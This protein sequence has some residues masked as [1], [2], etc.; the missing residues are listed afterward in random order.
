M[1]DDRYD[2]DYSVGRL[3]LTLRTRAQLSQ[4]ELGALIGVS[5]RSVQKWEGGD[6]YP[7]ESSLSRLLSVLLARG[8]FEAGREHEQA[9]ELWEMVAARGPRLPL[10]DAAWFLNLVPQREL[11]IGAAATEL[12]HS[13]ASPQ[14]GT[15]VAP[16]VDLAEAPDTA[17]LHGRAA[18][19]TMLEDWV[20]VDRCRI[21]ALLGMG[22][23]GKTSLAAVF[24]RSYASAFAR[25]VFR[26]LRN[27]PPLPSLLDGLLRTLSGQP[28]LPVPQR[29]DDKLS[30]L[31]GLLA[32][33]R[34]LL[35]LDNLET[36]M[37]DG[38]AAGNYRSGYADY[39]QL[40]QRL[41]EAPHQSCLLLTSR[42]KPRELG[43]LEGSA[44]PV[45][46]LALTGI[47]E[48]ACQAILANRDV[49]GQPGDWS[50]LTARYGGNPLALKLVAEPIR[51]LFGGDL[52]G[53]L[54]SE[55]A[56]FGGIRF[57][58]DEQF[59]RLSSLEQ[60][61]LYWMAVCR[62]PLGIEE[63]RLW[64]VLVIGTQERLEALE[65]LRR[66]FL[67]ERAG[68]ALR[69]TLQPVV[70][71][72]V[73]ERLIAAIVSE[74][75]GGNLQ[76]LRRY[77]LLQAQARAYVRQSQARVIVAPLLDMLRDQLKRADVV[78]AQLLRT[79]D[80]LRSVPAQEQSY[81]GGNLLNLLVQLGSDLRGRDLSGLVLWQA[82]LSGV[83]LP[84]VSLRD[85]DLRGT[86]F[87]E[88]F[89]TIVPVA[90]SP[91]GALLAAGSIDGEVGLWQV[92]DG[93]QV[94]LFAAHAGPVNSLSWNPDGRS[95]ASAG[96]D[97]L[98]YL[99]V[100][101]SGVRL[102]SL[103]GHRGRVW[104]VRWSPDG[105][106][107]ASGG[108]DGTVRLWDVL[109]AGAPRVLDEHEAPVASV[110]W[111][112]DG[113]RLVSASHDPR[114]QLK[115][116]DVD[117]GRCMRTFSG[118]TA[119]IW[120]VA[121][122]PDGTHIASGS[123][124]L[125][126]KLWDADSGEC[127]ATLEGHT[128][129]IRAIAWSPD[130][131]RLVSGSLDQTVR[132]WDA[133]RGV[134]LALLSENTGP[135]NGVAW[136]GDGD[137]VAGGGELQ[138]IALWSAH[139]GECLAL[140]EGYNSGVLALAYRPDGQ[141]V[142]SAGFDRTIRLW[143][144]VPGAPERRLLGHR[145]VIYA[146][147]WSPDGRLLASASGGN[148]RTLRIWDVGGGVELRSF[149][150]HQSPILTVCWSG[151]G[152]LIASGS[153][154]ATIKLWS[155]LRAASMA[156]LE[157]HGGAVRGMRF[158]PDNSLLASGSYD[159][160]VRIW[161]VATGECLTALLGHTAPVRI[162][163]WHPSGQYL[164]SGSADHSIRLWE[165]AS[166]AELAVLRGHAGEV[167]AL[168]FSPDGSLLASGS[169]DGTVQIWDVAELRANAEQRPAPRLS[170]Q[171]QAGVIYTLDWD[172]DGQSIVS[173]SADGVLHIWSVVTI[174]SGE[175]QNL[176][177]EAVLRGEG[178][179][180]RMDIS[181]VRGL[182]DAQ[183]ATLRALGA[184]ETARAFRKNQFGG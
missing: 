83:E 153:L 115:L 18:T 39:G 137:S 149:D 48:E 133:A 23:I 43:P 117:T 59:D 139:S 17:V 2:K 63:L 93:Q 82:Y 157:G 179:Y 20:L 142:A 176:A 145:S 46:V 95:L 106:R 173:G 73:S 52:H 136:S 21:V 86:L 84:E 160:S 164:A 171:P 53:F 96:S 6:G 116:W 14:A 127:L 79:L 22:G 120:A 114:P 47:A 125:S 168:G 67:I 102:A 144:L 90:F 177:P 122:S 130:G 54:A 16:L 24:A 44:T 28:Q 37:Q 3:L 143:P 94:A 183:R 13:A 1:P 158:S 65:A 99:W 9:Q 66:R 8:A 51:E 110:S 57:L 172:P 92:A 89:K 60:D 15:P 91:D 165:V 11:E 169:F 128:A 80:R 35:I 29:L 141:L 150:E 26:S 34:C 81:A 109:G 111:S 100:P 138:T 88:N 155:P 36:L 105:T 77:A 40:I 76:H 5:R 19:I 175:Q 64:S 58:L 159:R 140:L 178:P 85:A 97:G 147:A 162:V 163:A 87:S 98:L 45:R 78:E 104:S 107:L 154:D 38:I 129:R 101:T 131:S 50:V 7:G 152:R 184:I 31:V 70:M 121:W 55:G 30:L 118:H 10:F 161:N 113:T 103:S 62:E 134:C 33:Q 69:F 25:V 32:E 74:L 112:P 135:V 181:G 132:I 71:E 166:G 180:A 167:P 4:A 41:G 126:L 174:L 156:T 123:G 61:L 68:T 49:F 151:D 42:E 27:A 182:T 124:D 170:L 75:D 12:R 56:L 119:D 146:L 108:D 148:D 72:Y